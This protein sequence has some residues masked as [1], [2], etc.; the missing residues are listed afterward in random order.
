[1]SKF[2]LLQFWGCYSSHWAWEDYFFPLYEILSFFFMVFSNPH[3]PD[4]FMNFFRNLED[5]YY[6]HIT[7]NHSWSIILKTGYSIPAVSS[8]LTRNES[9]CIKHVSLFIHRIVKIPFPYSPFKIPP[10]MQN[11][12]TQLL[13]MPTQSGTA[14]P[15]E[16]CNCLAAAGCLDDNP[17][18]PPYWQHD[19]VFTTQR[20]FEQELPLLQGT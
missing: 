14:L 3:N 17:T 19:H 5:F 6:I 13:A 12:P 2:L 8:V 16:I 20:D 11:S 10:M 9:L 15:W 4:S 18:R 7:L 1:M